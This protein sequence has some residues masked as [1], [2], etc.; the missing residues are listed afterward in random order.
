[1]L[2]A[3]GHPDVEQVESD[4]ADATDFT[5]LWDTSVAD[6]PSRALR[7]ERV[8][9]LIRSCATRPSQARYRVATLDGSMVQ[10]AAASALLKLFE[11][12]GP[13]T[14]LLLRAN[15]VEGLPPPIASR[16]QIVP[17]RPVPAT[18]IARWL[19]EAD[20]TPDLALDCAGVSGGRPGLALRLAKTPG[21]MDSLGKQVVTALDLV[22][23][24]TVARIEQAGIWAR[25]YATTRAAIDLLSLVWRDLMRLA[26]NEEV[27]VSLRSAR[28]AL[29]D[30]AGQLDI[31]TLGRQLRAI[32][33]A[34]RLLD[35]NVQPRL[36]LDWLLL[37]LRGPL[38]RPLP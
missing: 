36:L 35:A 4:D 25:N 7:I 32:A 13:S 5:A 27:S 17:L 23:A 2:L 8:R 29:T 15:A 19:G 1:M 12:P 20:I 6:R 14:V 34:S 33:R 10:D 30:L 16:C 26:A 28:P 11:E 21:A 38:P 37:Q 24:D 22:G 3:N 31:A 9:E 18:D